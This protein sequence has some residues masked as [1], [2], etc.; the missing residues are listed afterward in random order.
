MLDGSARTDSVDQG[1]GGIASVETLT[2]KSDPADDGRWLFKAHNGTSGQAQMHLFGVCVA[3]RSTSADGHTHGIQLSAPVTATDNFGSGRKTRTLTCPND[4]Y[5][6]APGFRWTSG[7]GS[8]YLSESSPDGRSWTFGFETG[9]GQ[10]ETSVRCLNERTTT[11]DGHFEILDLSH[12]H[13]FPTVAPA[14]MGSSQPYSDQ[15]VSC[16][17]DE[18]A[19]VG[20]FDLPA[21]VSQ[22]GSTPEPKVR[23]F[24]ILNASGTSQTVH[25]DALCLGTRIGDFGNGGSVT[26]TACVH[27]A[28]PDP[29]HGNDCSSYVLEDPPGPVDPVDPVDPP[30]VDPGVARYAGPATLTRRA[31]L[32]GLRCEGD[33]ACSDTATVTA[34]AGGERITIGTQ[35]FRIAAGKSATL[36]FGL[37]RKLKRKL[38][39]TS[40]VRVDLAKGDDATLRLQR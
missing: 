29:V 39:R 9:G 14:D 38:K 15:R 32:V 11:D 30:T 3:E 20:T 5:A 21:G 23:D 17:N 16:G 8:Q 36:E 22:L 18:K 28:E 2:S 25:I 10:V 37:G 7:S 27:G 12:A 1:T 6:V 34:R 33:T 26:N 40:S 19:I 31:L 13:A 35:G 24:R 4:T